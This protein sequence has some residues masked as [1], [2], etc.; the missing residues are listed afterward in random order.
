VHLETSENTRDG[1]KFAR[2]A[3]DV[4]ILNPIADGRWDETPEFAHSDAVDLSATDHALERPWMHS[5]ELR[6][7]AAFEKRLRAWTED[8]SGG[9]L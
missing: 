4:V 8:S 5:K 2:L 9:A 7:L 6:R 1:S 3:G